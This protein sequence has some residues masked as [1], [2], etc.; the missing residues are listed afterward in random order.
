MDSSVQWHSNELISTQIDPSHH[1]QHS[2]QPIYSLSD[3]EDHS[4]IESRSTVHVAT[5]ENV[6]EGI[7]LG[8]S[9]YARLQIILNFPHKIASCRSEILFLC[10]N[11]VL[12]W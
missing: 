12:V 9:N 2:D 5:L 11:S 6:D 4:P 3:N 7:F 1:S 8:T 10:N